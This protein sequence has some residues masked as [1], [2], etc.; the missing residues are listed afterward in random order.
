[1]L[2]FVRP[3]RGIR[4]VWVDG[5][6]I[7]QGNVEERGAQVVTMGQ[8]YEQR[9]RVIVYLGADLVLSTQDRFPS[10]HLLHEIESG[11][12]HPQLPDGC[13]LKNSRIN[14]RGILKRNYFNR[15]WVIQELIFSQRA[16]IR[17][18]DVDFSTGS[19][20]SAHLIPTESTDWK[21]DL[22]E[23]PWFQYMAKR[24]F[25]M[26]IYTKCCV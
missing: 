8:I 19:T 12:I 15:I 1:M 18:G 9:S 14:L 24:L 22:T 2:Q 16:I 17:V 11:S 25:Q 20:G 5:L 4:M 23:A 13:E 6:C 21:W 7:N 10:H 3:W 26:A